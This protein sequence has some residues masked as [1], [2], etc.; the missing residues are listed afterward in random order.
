MVSEFQWYNMENPYMILRLF[1]I[2]EALYTIYNAISS[3]K[4][5]N[6]SPTTAANH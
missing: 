5:Q 4:L 6:F 3:S 2:G 1:S